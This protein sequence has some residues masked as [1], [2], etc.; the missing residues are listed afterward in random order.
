MSWS[1]NRRIISGSEHHKILDKKHLKK[2][3]PTIKKYTK[4]KKI[5]YHIWY[6]LLQ[7]LR[8]TSL[9][10]CIILLRQTAAVSSDQFLNQPTMSHT[11]CHSQCGITGID[12]NNHG[13]MS[14]INLF[15]WSLELSWKPIK[16]FIE[17]IPAGC[18]SCLNVPITITQTV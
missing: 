9:S 5:Q 18:T 12:Y 4:K 1:C 15:S 14:M 13:E 2:Q 16:S 10:L 8:Q 17:T 3:Q 6:S 7:F 11:E